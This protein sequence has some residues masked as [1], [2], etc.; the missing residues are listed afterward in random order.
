M[1]WEIHKKEFENVLKM[2]GPE[3]YNYFIQK[4]AD[5]E[6]VWGLKAEDGWAMV[7]DPNSNEC[8]PFWPHPEYAQVCAMDTK[9][10]SPMLCP[11]LM[12]PMSRIMWI[13]QER[14]WEGLS[15]LPLFATGQCDDV[16]LKCNGWGKVIIE[17]K[18]MDLT[19]QEAELT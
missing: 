8:I 12:P 19:E 16:G 9:N 15:P 14:V 2:N 3:R 5:W 6:E 1:T 11:F 18:I 17:A 10:S 4:V 7:G 13:L